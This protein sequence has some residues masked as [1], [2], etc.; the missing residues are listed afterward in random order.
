MFFQRW[1]FILDA[2]VFFSLHQRTA[3]R[4]G[5]YRLYPLTSLMLVHT[6]FPVWTSFLVCMFCLSPKSG[7]VMHLRR[8]IRSP[9]NSHTSSNNSFTWL[10]RQSDEL[11]SSCCAGRRLEHFLSLWVPV[12]LFVVV[13]YLLVSFHFL[14]FMSRIL[15]SPFCLATEWVEGKKEVKELLSFFLWYSNFFATKIFVAA[16][17][18]SLKQETVSS[19]PIPNPKGIT[20]PC[21]PPVLIIIVIIVIVIEKFFCLS[22]GRSI[23]AFVMSEWIRSNYFS[24]H[25][26]V[27]FLLFYCFW[28]KTR[29]EK[30]F[31]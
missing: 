2:E 23:T 10:K 30:Q 22:V 28:W 1:D 25:H 11:N 15:S 13:K 17:F 5:I 3:L 12:L 26:L 20:R 7:K 18:C 21:L 8:E 9:K 19:D 27:V 4:K 31:L 29:S 24:S 6:L 16:I 14:L